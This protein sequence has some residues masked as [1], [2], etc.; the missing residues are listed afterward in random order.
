MDEVKVFLKSRGKITLLLVV[1]NVLV[2]F[3][4]DFGETFAK[5]GSWME[6]GVIYVPWILERKEYYRLF[7]GM[8]LHFGIEH[9]AGNMLTL[10]FLGD[11]LEKMIGKWRFTVIYFLGGIAGNLLSLAEELWTGEFAI[12]AGASGAVFA[13]MGGLVFLVIIHRGKIP[14][15]SNERL[16]FMALLSLADGFFA[17]GVGYMAHLGGMLAGFVLTA[18]LMGKRRLKQVPVLPDV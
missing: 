8:F 3:I 11:F 18:V 16:V 10:I 4:M 12:S 1:V 9:L 13:V 5:E 7:T 2:F 6:G 14:G 15:I 17:E